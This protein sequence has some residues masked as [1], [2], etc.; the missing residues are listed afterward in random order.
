MISIVISHTRVSHIKRNPIHRL[1][2][3]TVAHEASGKFR[4]TIIIVNFVNKF[5]YYSYL[6]R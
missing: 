6:I 4:F 3:F 2:G 5:A 1:I